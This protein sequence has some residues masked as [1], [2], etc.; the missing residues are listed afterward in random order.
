ML[1]EKY[2]RVT[3]FGLSL[4][5]AEMGVDDGAQRQRTERIDL[6]HA[7]T[8]MPMCKAVL[9]FNAAD[10]PGALPVTMRRPDWRV[11]PGMYLRCLA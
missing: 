9:Y 10:A 6:Q 3:Q 8:T 1:K 5:V 2:Q 7:M 4:M 11:S